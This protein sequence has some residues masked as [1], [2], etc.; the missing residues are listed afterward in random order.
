M[1]RYHTFERGW[2]WYCHEAD[3]PHF[4]CK[5]KLLGLRRGMNSPAKSPNQHINHIEAKICR[6]FFLKCEDMPMLKQSR[7]YA[8]TTLRATRGFPIKSLLLSTILRIITTWSQRVST[9]ACFSSEK[10]V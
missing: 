7:E 2:Y 6:G 10:D 3:P 4:D 1:R 5:E 9:R 8:N